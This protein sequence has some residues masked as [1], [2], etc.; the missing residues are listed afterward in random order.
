MNDQASLAF[1]RSLDLAFAEGWT[2]T[3]ASFADVPPD[4]REQAI[5]YARASTLQAREAA[6][7]TAVARMADAGVT[8]PDAFGLPCCIAF[9]FGDP[10]TPMQ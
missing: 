10:D 3:L 5:E 4:Q 7:Q 9:V 6:R 8:V 1:A 2:N